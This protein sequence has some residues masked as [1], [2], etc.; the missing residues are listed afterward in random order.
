[1]TRSRTL[2]AVVGLLGLLIGFSGCRSFTQLP[3]GGVVPDADF[4]A[5]LNSDYLRAGKTAI[6][7]A[8][9]L[10]ALKGTVEC[11]A[12]MTYQ[13]KSIEGAQYL[14]GITTLDVS[15]NKISDLSPLENLTGLTD[16]DV[17]YNWPLSDMTPLSKLTN[18]TNLG[19]GANVITDFT[20]LVKLTKL[21]TLSLRFSGIADA[22][23]LSG[24]T[25][26]EELDLA[27]TEVT[28]ATPL[29]NLNKLTTLDISRTSLA[30]LAPLAQMKGLTKLLAN[31]DHIS[32]VTP[33]ASSTGLTTLSLN[34]NQI[35]DITPLRG[36]KNLYP[37]GSLS[38]DEQEIVATAIANTWVPL[39]A[40]GAY[41]TLIWD[42]AN[43]T[44]V[45]TTEIAGDSVRYPSPGT[46]ILAFFDNTATFSGT[47]TVTVT[48]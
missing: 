20:T 21:T 7:T 25:N 1:M 32:D 23:P 28:D 30:N 11:A 2:G 36:L 22:M 26:L 46:S 48:S 31:N 39:P 27:F 43:G 4:R 37:N 8:S 44:A 12:P 16:L 9:Q 15:S 29:T 42:D 5:C 17:G 14:T 13:I 40:I 41:S 45:P 19:L 6:I 10:G 34:G 38:A 33:L 47:V 35:S 3:Q 18:L 24:L